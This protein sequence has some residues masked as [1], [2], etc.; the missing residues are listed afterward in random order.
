MTTRRGQRQVDLVARAKTI[1]RGEKKNVSL[2]L[3]RRRLERRQPTRS[4][5]Y[6]PYHTYVILYK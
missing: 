2:D 1:R 3:V 6:S 4:L 5:I